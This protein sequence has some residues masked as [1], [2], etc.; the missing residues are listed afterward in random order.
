MGSKKRRVARN[1]KQR[2]RGGSGSKSGSGSGNGNGAKI[3][4]EVV[5]G[6]AGGGGQ[7]GAGAEVG[8]AAKA[9][10]QQEVAAAG[11]VAGTRAGAGAETGAETGAKETETKEL[12]EARSASLAGELVPYDRYALDRA[13]T[14]WQFGDWESLA[15]LS[16]EEIRHH[17][18]RAHLA[19]W[20]AA[21]KLQTG[22][23]ED[24]A[25]A[26]HLIQFAE[27]WGAAKQQ[28]SRILIA[29]V[30]NTL[31]RTSAIAGQQLRAVKHFRNSVAIGTPGAEVRLITE[32]RATRQFAACYQSPLQLQDENQSQNQAQDQGQ[33]QSQS[34]IQNHNNTSHNTTH[35]RSHNTNHNPHH[36]LSYSHTQDLLD[37][38][39]NTATDTTALS[40]TL[41]H[42]RPLLTETHSADA[43]AQYCIAAQDVHA[44]VDEIRQTRLK[45]LSSDQQLAFFLM[46]SD[47]LFKQH[48]DRMTA[49]SY[50]QHAMRDIKHWSPRS[51]AKLISRLVA[52]GYANLAAKFMT[53]LATQ[54]VGPIRL[55]ATD[56]DAVNQAS[57]TI[58]QTAAQNSEHGHDLLLAH[59]TQH[60][61]QY[62]THIAPAKPILIEIGTTREDVPG[63]GST[64]KLAMFCKQ[65]GI[66]FITVDM[67][68]HNSLLAREMFREIGTP[69]FQ[70]ITMKG[71][72]YLREYQGTLDFVFLDAYD[73]DHGKHSEIRQSRYTQFLGSRIDEAQCHQMHLECAESVHAKLHPSGLVC[74]DDTWRQNGQWTAKG[75]L[76]MPYLLEHGFELLQARNRA[77][78]LQRK[79]MPQP[80][81]A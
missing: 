9:V 22:G 28:I 4:D 54:G 42:P 27:Q 18:E 60:I 44:A 55:S 43:L 65:H 7:G 20:I 24:T 75:T 48:H 12:S 36:V 53:D 50:L 51:G 71:E 78:L 23:I 47:G 35:N 34:Q 41:S 1:R 32:A 21:G 13:R 57:A 70:A 81:N 19:L 76:A 67:D 46:L 45:K 77:A 30:Y 17:P 52:L 29:G 2:L 14:Q 61:A 37:Q 38:L 39:D 8:A 63:Q 11:A 62:K 40:R 73:F 3:R 59:L 69:D 6:V 10:T 26:K 66:G 49:L 33:T 72:D 56:R 16:E 5:A 15:Q 74:V 79:A 25:E 31:G 58:H 64:R 80:A 68:P